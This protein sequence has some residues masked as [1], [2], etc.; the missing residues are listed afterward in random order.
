MTQTA[1]AQKEEVNSQLST[2]IQPQPFA[3]QQPRHN[4]SLVL[5]YNASADLSKVCCIIL[6]QSQMHFSMQSTENIKLAS[7]GLVMLN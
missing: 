3:K 5:A 1:T 6:V 7:Q 4:K 2:H